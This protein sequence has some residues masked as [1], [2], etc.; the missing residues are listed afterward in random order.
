MHLD[1]SVDLFQLPNMETLSMDV[2]KGDG[3]SKTII[4]DFLIHHPQV[5]FCVHINEPNTAKSR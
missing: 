1:V 2:T 4:D 5:R 3:R